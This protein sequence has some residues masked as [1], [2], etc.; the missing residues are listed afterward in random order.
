M[1]K[2]S[3]IILFFIILLFID[4][5]LHGQEI[6]DYGLN[7]KRYGVS[8]KVNSLL[9][10][11]ISFDAFLTNRLNLEVSGAIFLAYG[12]EGGVNVHFFK[13]APKT[14]FGPWS[15]YAGAHAG[16]FVLDF[17][18]RTEY[19]TLYIP[20]GIQY[21]GNRSLSLAFDLGYCYQFIED[22]YTTFNPN[23]EGPHHTACGRL[24]IGLRF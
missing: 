10:G 21:L 11:G 1:S 8:L 20:V 12:A 17:L 15:P 6:S 2:T 5:Q 16:I 22:Q 9:A 3:R 24:K 4:P 13:E 23:T 19:K 14:T 18:T 7:K